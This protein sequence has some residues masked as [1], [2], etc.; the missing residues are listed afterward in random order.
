MLAR[1]A[2][3]ILH[4]LVISIPESLYRYSVI[5]LLIINE[6]INVMKPVNAMMPRMTKKAKNR[7][8]C[9]WRIEFAQIRPKRPPTNDITEA[10]EY[11]CEGRG[12]V[13]NLTK[14]KAATIIPFLAARDC[15]IS[16]ISLNANVTPQARRS[17]RRR[18][19]EMVGDIYSLFFPMQSKYARPHLWLQ[20][21]SKRPEVASDLPSRL[22]NTVTEPE[23]S[24]HHW[25]QQGVA[26]LRSREES[27]SRMKP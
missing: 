16:F 17:L 9:F 7:L 8:M 24:L 20:N 1:I 3:A 5:D 12:G 11:A 13:I 15:K 21:R 14:I 26:S 10:T 27:A 18:L 2:R 19:L 22:R 4:P 23:R 6:A 25:W